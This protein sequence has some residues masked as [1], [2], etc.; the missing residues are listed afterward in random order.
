MDES[1]FYEARTSGWEVHSP[2][3]LH[4][5]MSTTVTS[6]QG[7][8]TTEISHGRNAAPDTITEARKSMKWKLH[9]GTLPPAAPS[10]PH[11]RL[12]CFGS[13]LLSSSVRVRNHHDHWHL[14]GAVAQV[15]STLFAPFSDLT[16]PTFS[17][18]SFLPV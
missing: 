17:L 9:Y 1:A 3:G 14:E 2:T 15:Q 18:T 5:A 8:T 10:S 16:P 13:D 6:P 12:D 7:A 4:S 11:S